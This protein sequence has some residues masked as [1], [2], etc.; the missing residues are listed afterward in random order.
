MNSIAETASTY[1]TNHDRNQVSKNLSLNPKF[2][3]ISTNDIMNVVI[4]PIISAKSN[5]CFIFILLNIIVDKRLTGFNFL[6]EFN[7]K[8]ISESSVSQASNCWNGQICF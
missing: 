7:R 3:T 4:M 2:I 5:F 6:R 1:E 8:P